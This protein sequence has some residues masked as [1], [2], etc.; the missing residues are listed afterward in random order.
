MKSVA[1]TRAQPDDRLAH[2]RVCRAA[3]LLDAV[4]TPTRAAWVV[5]SA[6]AARAR[7]LCSVIEASDLREAV[8][9]FARDA[10]PLLEDGEPPRFRRQPPVGD[11]DGEVLSDRGQ[12]TSPPVRP[13]HGSPASRASVSPV[14]ERI[15]MCARS[16][17]RGVCRRRM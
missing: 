3:R 10:I 12:Q 9:Q 11:C 15:G 7:S 8:M 2:I 14:H 13:R 6:S 17:D 4:A 5:P 1:A 16:S